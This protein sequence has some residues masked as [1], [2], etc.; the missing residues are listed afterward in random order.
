M[1]APADQN[2][3]GTQNLLRARDV[4]RNIW[5][6]FLY[7]SDLA[8]FRDHFS[9]EVDESPDLR[10]LIAR[11]LNNTI[12]RRLR[13]GLSFHHRQRED[14]L[15]RVRGRIDVLNSFSRGLFERGKVACRYNELTLDTP[16][17]RYARAALI[18]L[19]AELGREQNVGD[20]QIDLARRCQVLAGAMLRAGVRGDKPSRAELATD[21]IARHESNDRLMVSLSRAV[22]DLILPTEEEGSRSF[23]EASR[24]ELKG[25]NGFP[26]L[27]EKAIGNFFKVELSRSDGWEVSQDERRYWNVECGSSGIGRYMPSMVC[28]IVLT[29]ERERRR[30]VIDTKFTDIHSHRFENT[31]KFKSGHIYQMYAYLRSQEGRMDDPH[32][33][34]SEGILL[35]PTLYQEVDETAVIQGHQI[36]FATV[37]LKQSSKDFVERLKSIPCFPW[38]PQ[39]HAVSRRTSPTLQSAS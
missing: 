38:S 11:L 35:Y 34:T 36:R 7:A 19:S 2:D 26:Y 17:N 33:F 20:D 21:Q 39:D 23:L 6:L 25:K 16:R 28:D 32:P 14:V 15:D 13:R 27:Y 10:S 31:D 30:I 4:V 3:D 12:D 5:I 1:S 24:E 9:A 37:S 29:N 22:F 8:R 18:R